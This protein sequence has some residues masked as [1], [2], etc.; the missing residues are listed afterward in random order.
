MVSR[1]A[2]VG[3]YRLLADTTTIAAA[4]VNVDTRESN[5]NPREL[6]ASF[7]G[8]ARIIDT[9]I[10]F[11]ASLQRERQGRE[12]YGLFLLLAVAALILESLLGRR[13]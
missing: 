9:T 12:I 8:A 6:D 2:E 11:A 3:F 1:P 10:D 7:I 5:L 4:A 13:A